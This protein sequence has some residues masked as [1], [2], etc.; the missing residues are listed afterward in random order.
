MKYN[1]VY[2]TRGKFGI[3]RMQCTHEE[4]RTYAQ[5]LGED[6]TVHAAQVLDARKAIVWSK[7]WGGMADQPKIKQYLRTFCGLT[8]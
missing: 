8:H 4:V 3:N 1:I 5:L 6:D 7:A 2:T